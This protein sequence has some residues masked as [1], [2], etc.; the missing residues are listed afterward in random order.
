MYKYKHK[1]TGLEVVV[2]SK[3]RGDWELVTDKKPTLL[4]EEKPVEEPVE[5]EVKK[6][7]KKKKK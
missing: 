7:T 5:K 6:T 3:L 4:S 2:E 1:K